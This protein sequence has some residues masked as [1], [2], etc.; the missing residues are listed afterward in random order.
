MDLGHVLERLLDR[1]VLAHG[2]VAQGVLTP[3]VRGE[4]CAALVVRV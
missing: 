3:G 1:L 4:Q 2:T